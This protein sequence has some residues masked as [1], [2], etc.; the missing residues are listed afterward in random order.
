[1]MISL[2]VWVRLSATTTCR[3]VQ[4]QQCAVHS[5]AHLPEMVF[6]IC[7]SMVLEPTC[8]S[9]YCCRQPTVPWQVT[10]CSGECLTV[11][12][13]HPLLTNSSNPGTLSLVF[14]KVTLGGAARRCIGPFADTTS[15]VGTS[16]MMSWMSW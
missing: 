3:L 16:S 6:P 8:L 10:V 13:F 1:M 9:E 7:L 4:A 15:C 14:T 5:K 2:A 11:T 12:C